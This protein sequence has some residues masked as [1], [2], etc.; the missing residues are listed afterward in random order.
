MSIFFLSL[1]RKVAVA[2]NV[3]FE[4]SCCAHLVVI[5]WRDEALS[6][7]VGRVVFFWRSGI[8]RDG[9]SESVVGFN[10]VNQICGNFRV[11]I[12]WA[13]VYVSQDL[14]EDQQLLCASRDV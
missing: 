4:L 14:V 7:G 2:L 11:V 3:L 9:W 13:E 8:L 6:L 5:L 12:R 10:D 1:N